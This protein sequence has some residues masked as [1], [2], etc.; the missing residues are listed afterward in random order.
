MSDCSRCTRQGETVK[1][2]VLRSIV[3]AYQVYFTL[4]IP[5]ISYLIHHFDPVAESDALL[6]YLI[7]KLVFVVASFVALSI[8][9][10]LVT[11]GDIGD[12]ILFCGYMVMY[13]RGLFLLYFTLY[14]AVAVAGSHI[15]FGTVGTDSSFVLATTIA[16]YVFLSLLLGYHIF[17]RGLFCCRGRGT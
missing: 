15:M 12:N 2:L 5:V 11:N 17:F 9:A 1:E 3:I 6:V 13:Y 10:C 16:D 8:G 14:S 7:V 4:E